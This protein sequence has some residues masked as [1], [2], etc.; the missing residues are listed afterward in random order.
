MN[1][2][3]WSRLTSYT[4]R[5][6]HTYPLS[7]FQFAK[8]VYIEGW[9]VF[10]REISCVRYAESLEIGACKGLQRLSQI[11]GESRTLKHIS[12]REV[13]GLKCVIDWREVGEDNAIL[14]GL[15]ILKLYGLESLEMVFDGAP[16]MTAGF[17]R[18]T[19]ISI[20]NCP[21]L[22]CI[23]SSSMLQH[24]HQLESLF[25]VDCEQLEEIVEGGPFPD[26]AQLKLKDLRLSWLPKLTTIFRQHLV[27]TSTVIF[28]DVEDCPLLKKLPVLCSDNIQEITGEIIGGREWW[29][30]IEWE[31]D[32]SKSLYS[33]IYKEELEYTD[34]GEYVEEDEDSSEDETLKQVEEAAA[35]PDDLNQ[36][37]SRAHIISYPIQLKPINW[38]V[39]PFDWR[40]TEN[41]LSGSD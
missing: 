18:L 24:P 21:K 19:D 12:V 7:V 22:T 32:H 5:S 25:V 31:D 35:R 13:E 3:M 2:P 20:E 9:I 14:G 30:G 8:N 27:L 10:P 6:F 23:F 39:K 17:G 38:V 29:E 40:E 34:E 15:E 33:T 11:I 4:V 37:D 28:I 41:S 26:T 16:R 36:L 1:H